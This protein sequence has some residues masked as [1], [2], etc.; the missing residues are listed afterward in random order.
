MDYSIVLSRQ[1]SK[2]LLSGFTPNNISQN[3]H[4]GNWHE[5]SRLVFE[6]PSGNP[7]DF[8]GQNIFSINEDRW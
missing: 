7:R 8:A 3:F 6:Y 1:K 5:S 4:R 2:V